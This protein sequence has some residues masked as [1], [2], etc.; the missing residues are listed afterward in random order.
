MTSSDDVTASPPEHAHAPNTHHA[1]PNGLQHTL[2]EA[3]A[4]SLAQLS[5]QYETLS[6]NQQDWERR[7]Q[8]NNNVHHQQQTATDAQPQTV[9]G[10]RQGER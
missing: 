1:S 7:Q 8:V 3:Y 6:M 10:T 5:Q 4:S 2:T 9:E